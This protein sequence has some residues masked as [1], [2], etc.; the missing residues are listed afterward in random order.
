[1]INYLISLI[2]VPH[3][4]TDLILSYETNTYIIMSFIYMFLPTSLIFLNN[5]LYKYLFIVSSY[6]HFSYDILYAVPYFIMNMYFLNELDYYE[7]YNYIIYYLSFIHTPQHYYDI[8]TNTN[9]FYEHLSLIILFTGVSYKLSPLLIDWMEIN[10]G[11]D[12]LSK[13]L[14]GI[15]L[16]HIYFNLIIYDNT[17]LKYL[18]I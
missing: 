11:K 4:I 14:G 6:I 3:G 12:K 5:T 16:S 17:L 13:F 2:I 10:S 8:F 1:M 15:I 9:L 18:K 7:S